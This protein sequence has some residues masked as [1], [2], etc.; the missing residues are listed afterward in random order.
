MMVSLLHPLADFI[1]MAKSQRVVD[2]SLKTGMTL[3]MV[4]KNLK[5]D[6]TEGG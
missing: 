2:R 1:C 3:R 4:E 6:D 5:P